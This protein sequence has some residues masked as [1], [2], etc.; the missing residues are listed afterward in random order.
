[1]T[2]VG[3]TD[4]VR[5][6]SLNDYVR[7][8]LLGPSIAVTASVAALYLFDVAPGDLWLAVAGLSGGFS[9]AE[10]ASAFRERD[11][12]A[13]AQDVEIQLQVL[14]DRTLPVLDRPEPLLSDAAYH[15]GVLA[16]PP[17]SAQQNPPEDSWSTH[18]AL[19]LG[20]CGELGLRFSAEE[21][22]VIG[23]PLSDIDAASQLVRKRAQTLRPPILCFFEL[24][25]LATWLFGLIDEIQAT[26]PVAERLDKL[27]ANPFLRLDSQYSAVLDAV[28][29]ALDPYRARIEE[30][31]RDSLRVEL[32]KA[33]GNGPAISTDWYW[34]Q[35]DGAPAAWR[36]VGPFAVVQREGGASYSV[37]GS[38]RMRTA[39]AAGVR[40][41]WKSQI[42]RRFKPPRDER[43]GSHLADEAI[44]SRDGEA[45]NCS[46]HPRRDEADRCWEVPLVVRA[47][48]GGQPVTK[49]R[50]RLVRLE[51]ADEN[52]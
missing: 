48:G 46:A 36:M 10:F 37:E 33:L 5:S 25:H 45:W 43:L 39:L 40:P 2:N 9:A 26:Q 18:V 19:L 49:A 3:D 23:F 38:Q 50:T 35:D 6:T 41:S 12:R 4:P 14:S 29:A 32:E 42:A 31:Q 15:L 52:T 20:F 16:T 21:H 28:R 7:W 8:E 22:R 47:S 27:D 24:G 17:A 13:Q 34:V 44:V 1:V 11:S 51:P 30:R